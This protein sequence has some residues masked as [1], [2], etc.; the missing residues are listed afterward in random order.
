MS[1][2]RA[3]GWPYLGAPPL[4]LA[5]RGG[6]AGGPD[7]GIENSL[8]AFRSAVGLGYRYLETDVHATAD[9]QVV[10]FHDDRLD[11]VTDG[12]GL[13]ARLPWATVAQARIAGREPV[14]LLAELLEELPTA[15]F[16]IDLKSSGAVEPLWQVLRAHSALDRVCV[17]SFSDRRLAAFRRLAGDRVATAAGPRETAAVR[18]APAPLR[19]LAGLPAAV[20]QVPVVHRIG[21]V[22]LRLVTPGFVQRAH[23]LGKQVHVWTVDDPD[24]MVRLLD[25][26]VDGLVS[27]R[28]DV[29]KRV[30]VERGQWHDEP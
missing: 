7:Q 29:L 20:L 8:A 6:V 14:P 27:D 25:L 17:A 1:S 4:A 9:G 3:S 22:P 21:R 19:A 30:L 28:I 12:S 16:N 11:R 18:F 2:T 23:R 26:G 13:V 5:H 15:R 10:A 24:E